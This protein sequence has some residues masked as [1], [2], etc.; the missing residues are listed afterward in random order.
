MFCPVVGTGRAV[1]RVVVTLCVGPVAVVVTMIE[2]VGPGAVET[3][4]EIVVNVMVEALCVVLSVDTIVLAGSW[5]VTVGPDAVVTYVLAGC[6]V[7][8][9]LVEAG[10]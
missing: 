2:V 1:T 8:T 9:S 6:V 3:E 4:T 7:V 10:S 5:D